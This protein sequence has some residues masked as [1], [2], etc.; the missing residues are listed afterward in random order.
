MKQEFSTKWISSK[1]KRKQVKYRHNVPLH[2]RHRLMSANL[3]KELRKKYA[4]RNFPLR[5]GDKV[6]V[7]R[8]KFSGKEG[9]VANVN[10]NRLRITIEGLQIQKKDG[11]KV[12]IYFNPSKVQIQELSLDDKE[13][14]NSMNRKQKNKENKENAS[15]KK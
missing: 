14:L 11:T 15:N 1:Q 6:K 3:S 9:K 13:R 2:L 7:M 4:K 12:N 8:G 5:K 10:L